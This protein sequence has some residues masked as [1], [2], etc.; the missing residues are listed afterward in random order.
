MKREIGDMEKLA[1]KG[2]LDS[3][4]N[5]GAWTTRLAAP[6]HLEVA[7]SRVHVGAARIQV[8]EGDF[9]LAEFAWDDGRISTAGD[10]SAVPL[11]TFARVA[12]TPLPFQ[13]TLT[14]SGEWKLATTPRLNGTLAVRRQSGDIVIAQGTDADRPFAVGITALETRARFDD[15]AIDASGTFRSTRGDRA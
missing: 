12:G 6:A 9:N 11:A 7:R 14:L 3:F 15:D 4:E 10:F 13:S 1:W 5:R 8:A 2:T